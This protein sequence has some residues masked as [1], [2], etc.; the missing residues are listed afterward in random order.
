MHRT[1]VGFLLCWLENI[2]SSTYRLIGV[3]QD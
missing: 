2:Y 3:V 1:N